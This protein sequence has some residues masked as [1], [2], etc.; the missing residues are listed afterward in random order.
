MSVPNFIN[1]ITGATAWN[2]S[3]AFSSN[4]FVDIT[5]I[6][7]QIGTL[8]MY[9]KEIEKFPHP[10]ST[11]TIDAIAKKWDSKDLTVLKHFIY[12]KIQD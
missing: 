2:S 10:R 8:T 3:S 1:M 6:A 4:I 7:S 12:R 5:G 9:K 11:T